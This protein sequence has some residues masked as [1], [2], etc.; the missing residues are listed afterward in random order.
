MLHRRRTSMPS[1]SNDDRAENMGK[2][3]ER[4]GKTERDRDRE[5]MARKQASRR[6]RRRRRRRSECGTCL[7]IQ[8]V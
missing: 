4:V 6:R 8:C 7:L 1:K 3:R 5:R 2:T